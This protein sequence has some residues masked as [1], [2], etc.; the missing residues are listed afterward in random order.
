MPTGPE[1]PREALAA[2]ANEV[3]RLKAQYYGK[4]PTEAKAFLNDETLVVVLKG[5]LTTVE[6]TLLDAGDDD[7][8]RRVRLRFQVVMEQSFI[9]SVQ[10]LTRQ[11][12]LTYMSQIV[13]DPD[14]CFEFFVLSD[15]KVN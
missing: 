12:V 2:V 8:V 11:K 6:R 7:L 5:G 3:V 10:R 9:D 1:I 15:E 13:F 4:G 14:F